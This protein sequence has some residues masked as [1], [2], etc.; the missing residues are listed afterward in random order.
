V[1]MPEDTG[2]ASARNRLASL[3]WNPTVSLA[4]WSGLLARFATQIGQ[5]LAASEAREHFEALGMAPVGACPA[6]FDVP[7]AREIKLYDCITKGR[8]ITTGP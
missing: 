3:V 2:R 1:T 8:G 6:E 4:A 7:I 5:V